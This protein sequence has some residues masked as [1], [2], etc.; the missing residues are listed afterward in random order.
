MCYIRLVALICLEDVKFI[1]PKQFSSQMRCIICMITEGYFSITQTMMSFIFKVRVI[2]NCQILFRNFTWSENLDQTLLPV[3]CLQHM[4]YKKDT[5]RTS[6]QVIRPNVI[7]FL[8][9]GRWKCFISIVWR[10]LLTTLLYEDPPILPI[11]PLSKIC[12]PSLSPL[13][14]LL[15]C[16]LHCFFDWMG[17]HATSGML[18]YLTT[19]KVVS[20][21]FVLV[22]FLSLDESTCQTRKNV[23]ISLQE[24]FSFSRKSNFRIL[25]FQISWRH[26]MPKQKTRNTFH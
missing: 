8:G 17:D 6:A 18:F 12:P 13:F 25:H 22:C 14:T 26:Q 4:L 21:T 23:F 16:S 1:L 24:L 15:L 19:L 10:G 5:V 20:A 3:H 9:K 2:C 11:L 7:F